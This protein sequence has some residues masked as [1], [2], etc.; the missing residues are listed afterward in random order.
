MWSMTN[1]LYILAD[2]QPTSAS[3]LFVQLVCKMYTLVFRGLIP[4]YVCRQTWFILQAK[5]I[6]I[7][8]L[9][10]WLLCR[11]LP[12]DDF[13]G[14]LFTAQISNYTVHIWFI[15]DIICGL[16]TLCVFLF[17]LQA[18][19]VVALLSSSSPP[20]PPLLCPRRSDSFRVKDLRI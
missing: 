9:D 11:H 1:K 18:N 7:E 3:V 6:I 20:P 10:V 17:S 19:H 4:H 2:T 13:S 16:W 12:M 8:T 14:Q 5:W 15:Y